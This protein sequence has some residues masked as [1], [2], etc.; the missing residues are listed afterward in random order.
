MSMAIAGTGPPVILIHGNGTYSYAWR[1][2]IPFLAQQHT[3]FAPDLLGMGDSDVVAPSGDS[4]YGFEDQSTQV[5][6]LI[7]MLVGD[8]P[9]VIVGHELG[10]LFAIQHA[11]RNPQRVKGLIIVEGVFRIS[12]DMLFAEHLRNFLIDVRGPEGEQLVLRENAIIDYWL[13][14]L[15]LRQLPPTEIEY[16]RAPY[17]VA[18]EARRP[19]L[20]MIRQLPIRSRPGPLDELAEQAR[21]WSAQSRIPKLVIGGDPGFLVPASILGTTARWANTTTATSRGLHFL[22]EDS[23]A[24]LT[25]LIL[26]WLNQI[27]Q[28]RR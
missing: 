9:V 25:T 4:S 10:A 13:P 11:R 2:V 22:M 15:T 6:L 16:Y 5:D 24:R 28:I 3:C 7:D 21:L 26:D 17:R 23:P 14:Q 27:W 20:S 8:H 19:L 12:N 1:N 18:G